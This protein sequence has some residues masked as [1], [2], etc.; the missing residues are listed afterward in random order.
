MG[1]YKTEKNKIYQY[2]LKTLYE[3]LISLNSNTRIQ[4]KMNTVTNELTKLKIY[5]NVKKS[6]GHSD[7][8]L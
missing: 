5:K 8:C 3:M 4:E 2:M 6:A 7:A 1:F